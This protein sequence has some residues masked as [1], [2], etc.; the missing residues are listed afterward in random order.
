M[1]IVS[2]VE[3]GSKKITKSRRSVRTYTC[4][5]RTVHDGLD[6]EAAFDFRDC[7]TLLFA[8][9]LVKKKADNVQSIASASI[10]FCAILISSAETIQPF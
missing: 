1:S 10:P 4:A 6:A 3:E 2:V 7:A 9:E 8:D 5:A